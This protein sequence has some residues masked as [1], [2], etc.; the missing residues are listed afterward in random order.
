MGNP[1]QAALEQTS[2]KSSCISWLLCLCAWLWPPLRPF[3]NILATQR[4]TQR[5]RLFIATL[6]ESTTPAVETTLDNPK[7]EMEHPPKALTL[8]N[9][10]MEDSKR[11]PTPSKEMLVM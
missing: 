3:L 11:W 1:A 7:A 4:D 10:L 8:S 6:M 2:K 9:C 5:A